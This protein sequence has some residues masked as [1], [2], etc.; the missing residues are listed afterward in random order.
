MSWPF[1]VQLLEVRGGR[2]VDVG[3]IV[4]HRCWILFSCLFCCYS[5]VSILDI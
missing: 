2:F 5:L 3:R 1:R 4:E